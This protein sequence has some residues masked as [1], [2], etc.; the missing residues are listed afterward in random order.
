MVAEFGDSSNGT[1]DRN[2]F[3]F[4]GMYYEISSG[5]QVRTFEFEGM[6]GH[7]LLEI[8]KFEDIDARTS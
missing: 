5:R 2:D 4:H 6:P 7:V 3:A 1:L 8:C